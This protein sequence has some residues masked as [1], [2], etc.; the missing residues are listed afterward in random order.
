MMKFFQNSKIEAL[1]KMPF[2]HGI[3][4]INVPVNTKKSDLENMLKSF[5]DIS[6]V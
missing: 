1:E 2:N 5:G 3:R 4:L 6:G